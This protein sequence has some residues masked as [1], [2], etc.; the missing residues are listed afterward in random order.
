MTSKYEEPDFV[1]GLM[2]PNIYI[3]IYI[4]GHTLWDT[5]HENTPGH[6]YTSYSLCMTIASGQSIPIEP[7]YII[8]ETLSCIPSPAV[9][10]CGISLSYSLTSFSMLGKSRLYCAVGEW[11]KARVMALA[12]LS[13]QITIRFSL[14][15]G[16]S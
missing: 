15:S 11:D 14:G 13:G 2:G 5:Q 16:Q 4:Y 8:L 1:F 7:S 12:A 6:F 3:Y 9:C 10:Y